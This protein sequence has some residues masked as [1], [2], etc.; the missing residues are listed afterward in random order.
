M[1]DN[2]FLIKYTHDNKFLEATCKRKIPFDD[3]LSLIYTIEERSVNDDGEFSPELYELMLRYSIVEAFTD[4]ELP[5]IEK[6]SEAYDFLMFSTL[7][8][9]M[10]PNEGEIKDWMEEGRSVGKRIHP[11]QYLDIMASSYKRLENRRSRTPFDNL[12]EN[13]Q[14]LV[15]NM[16]NGLKGFDLNELTGALE[17]I[18]KLTPNEFAKSVLASRTE[19]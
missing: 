5:P 15:K 19:Q 17:Q 16:D 4:A 11:E 2:E 14:S 9:K 12:M 1:S 3:M 10:V 8:R 7:F 6:F 18:S 13:I